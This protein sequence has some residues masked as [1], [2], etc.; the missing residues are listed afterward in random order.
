MLKTGESRDRRGPEKPEQRGAQR[1]VRRESREGGA[2]RKIAVRFPNP[3]GREGRG[4]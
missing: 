4:A 1:A 2:A 3:R